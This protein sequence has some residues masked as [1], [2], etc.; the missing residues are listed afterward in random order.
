MNVVTKMNNIQVI[1]TEAILA[2]RHVPAIVKIQNAGFLICLITSALFAK[3]TV[4]E[5][6]REYFSFSWELPQIDTASY[7][8]DAQRVTSLTFDESNTA[9]GQ[10]GEPA[11]PG[12]AFYIGVP[13]NGTV[14]VSFS[15]QA[16]GMVMP[17]Y[18]PA[19][20]APHTGERIPVRSEAGI[21]VSRYGNFRSLRTARVVLQPVSFDASTGRITFIRKGT[22]VIRFPAS[23]YRR[24]ASS[25]KNDYEQ[26]LEKMVLNYQVATGWRDEGMFRKKEASPFPLIFNEH[27]YR[28]RI[29]DGSD[30]FNEST[31]DCNGLVRI[32]AGKISELF[33]ATSVSELKLFAAHKGM[34]PPELP[35]D[36]SVPDGI[37][38][39]PLYRV[40]RNGNGFFDDDDYVLAYVSEKSDWTVNRGS[41][42]C[43]YEYK[44]D[45][46]DDY[47]TYW[48]ATAGNAPGG[49]G[50]NLEVYRSHYDAPDTVVS[51]VN[52]I[53]RFEQSRIRAEEDHGTQRWFLKKMDQTQKNISYPFF[54][55]GL[56]ERG[57][58]TFTFFGDFNDNGAIDV[59]ID[60][61]LISRKVFPRRQVPIT[62]WG[63][64]IHFRF[65]DFSDKNSADVLIDYF[66]VEYVS[67]L[68]VGKS[69]GT[70]T[71]LPAGTFQERI[72]GFDLSVDPEAIAY[73]LRIPENEE[74][75]SLIAIVDG[76]ETE[77]FRWVDSII[78][79]VRYV[80][81]GGTSV[82]VLEEFDPLPSPVSSGSHL[83]HDLRSSANTT[84]FLIISHADFISAADSLAGHKKN[85]GFKHPV[86]ADV[87]DIYR[88]FSGGDK[89]VTA[90]RNFI[91]YVCRYWK[92]SRNLD[93]I[94]L[95]GIGHYDPKMHL[96]DA[97]DYLPVF[98][99]GSLCYE[100]YFTCVAPAGSNE[101]DDP[102]LAIGRLP[103]ATIDEAWSMVE[104][105]VEYENPETADFSEWRNRMLFVADDDMQGE[106][107]DNVALN[108]P[109]H[110]SSDRTASMI[111]T[112]WPSIAIRKVYL[113][114]YEW[115][116]ALQKPGAS[117]ALI[118]EI[119]NG[120]GYIN[121]FGHGSYV[122]WT[123]EYIL[124]R[125]M[126]AGMTNR[127][128]YPVVSA[129]SCSVGEFDTPGEECMS[130]IL[131][132]ADGVGS[133]ASVSST[134]QSHA[135]SNENLAMVFYRFL[136][137]TT[138]SRSIGMALIAAQKIVSG[139]GHRTYSIL[140]DPSVRA[141]RPTHRISLTLN[142]DDDTLAARQKV[143]VS[144]KILSAENKIDKEFAHGKGFVS[145]GLFNP[146]DTARRKDGGEREVR[147]V[148]PG[149]PAFLGRA[150]VLNGSFRQ[151]VLVPR[152][153]SFDQ[154]GVRLVAYAW[155]DD[156]Y[157]IGTGYRTGLV[158]SGSDTSAIHDT[159]G[160][161]ITIR[162]VYDNE[163]FSGI[164][165][166]F[167]DHI[168]IQT[169]VTCEA[170]L[171]DENGIDAAGIGPEE[172]VTLEIP[173]LISRQNVNSKLQFK[174]G[175][176]RQGIVSI[177]YEEETIQP[178][179]YE[180]VVTARDLIGNLSKAK[181]T[182]NVTQYDELTLDH[183]LNFPNPV[184]LGK[185][186]RF[187]CHT[188]YTSHEYY[189]ADIRLTV[190]IY[191]LGGRL[192]RVIRN[193]RNGEVWD[194]R[195]QRGNLLSP[196]VYLYQIV[197]EDMIL[198]K[199]E[200]SKIMKLVVL[201]PR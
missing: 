2:K 159:S 155:S 22:G 81:A 78:P 90:I 94:I 134:R 75:C 158:F 99:I 145:L 105:I 79:G 189:G 170:E 162:P 131:A 73:I 11:V 163:R 177:V 55:P 199:T 180:L 138:S 24:Q 4:I 56:D 130:G 61:Q 25:S 52:V 137:D 16:T 136:F 197:A 40:D 118:N 19:M 104:K 175:D 50:K 9:I 3:I 142:D 89:D 32:S 69:T 49:T 95:V 14:S 110:L 139:S 112:L 101:E 133:I 149:T 115:D 190:R 187:Y 108:N 154:E 166:S 161:N 181:F 164:N 107:T 124:T 153:L 33:G 188:N 156:G 126:V 66:D 58:G 29:G 45:L 109:H 42:E 36:G 85:V 87:E 88:C 77:S 165:A 60:D 141:V 127:G 140:G 31:T 151:T 53:R 17:A 132:K 64:T 10:A 8:T 46:Y 98:I 186:T 176:Y 65:N 38:E 173:G 91:G 111:D 34:L 48:L 39:V 30:G 146:P 37:V 83:V 194:C 97:V 178:G 121:F 179:T 123:D 63:D 92:N 54:L 106:D 195:D 148:L 114:E 171:F 15:P 129:F 23:S 103:C 117:R 62:T 185:K 57:E 200:K 20:V 193:A 172:G 5:S 59:Y 86:V 6:T 120:V 51:H 28:F 93:Y 157:D 192:L 125:E 184:R 102:Q 191:T 196:D 183:V 152:N 47:R 67:R 74:E 182:L 27:T 150:E 122:T 18:P 43:T 35:S 160:P 198:R 21:S 1:L 68:H 7:A 167:T 71:I 113:F 13:Q 76:S 96:T 143:I 100:D 82:T 116:Q 201:P 80:V 144:G 135:S 70:V 44:T 41:L 119:N 169:P 12:F 72:A 128:R 26:M 168:T 84:D 147:Y 174:N